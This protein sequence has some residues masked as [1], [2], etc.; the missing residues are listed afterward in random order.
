MEVAV[1]AALLPDGDATQNAA[2][3]AAVARTPPAKLAMP[4]GRCI[5][6][7]AAGPGGGGGGCWAA[8][9]PLHR[10]GRLAKRA[11]KRGVTVTVHAETKGHGFFGLSTKSAPLGEGRLS[12]AGLRNR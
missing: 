8:S 5:F 1:D 9:F 3:A 2:A 4:A 11:E 6:P 7:A 10:S 12:A